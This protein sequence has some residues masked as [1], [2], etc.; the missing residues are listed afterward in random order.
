MDTLQ[1]KYI[2]T[3]LSF[4]PHGRALVG[5]VPA[6]RLLALAFNLAHGHKLSLKTI[7]ATD[8][9]ARDGSFKI[10]YVFGAPLEQAWLVPYLTLRGG[11]SFPSLAPQLPEAALFERLIK[12]FFGLEPIGHPRPQPVL[13]HDTGLGKTHPLRKDFAW[14]SRVATNKPQPYTFE[15]VGGEGIYEVPVGPVHAGIIE[16]GHFRFS[17]AGEEIALLDPRLGYVHKGSEKLFEVLPFAEKIKLAERIAGDTAFTHALAYAQAVEELAGVTVPARALYLRVLFSELERLAN[18][19]NDI[20]FIMFDTGYNFG[21]SQGVRLR[22][23]IMQLNERLG[24]HR[25]LRG[26]MALGGVTRDLTVTDVAMLRQELAAIAQD[27]TE[28]LEVAENSSSVQHRLEGAGTITVENVR[29][30][31]GVGVPARAVGIARDTRRDFPY[32]AYAELSFEPAV[33]TSGDVAGRFQVRV[34]E[35]RTSFALIEQA[36]TQLPEGLIAATPLVTRLPANR[37]AVGV[38]EGW[39]GEIVYVVVTDGAGEIT[40]VAVRDPSVVNWQLVPHAGQDNVLLDF[41]LINKSFNLSYTG[42]DV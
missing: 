31:A 1:K 30:H 15:L 35:V 38:A 14:N 16:P 10:W 34:Q 28:V 5:E 20:G 4:V 6:D 2:P 39:R 25:F 8:E 21:G 23:R 24:G 37:L 29:N 32:A 42:N 40:R 36:L 18:H 3:D 19:F 41:P 33:A 17:M 26:V 9:R 27:F 12:E 13:L 7:V 22:E 11:E